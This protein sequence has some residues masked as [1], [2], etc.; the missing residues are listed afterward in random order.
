MA[1][2]LGDRE[3][4]GSVLSSA[5][6]SRGSRPDSEINAMLVEALAIGNELSH[7]GIRAEALWW[8]VPSY[9]SLSDHATARVALA[10][11]TDLAGQLGEP[12][13]LHVAEQYASALALCDG[14]LAAAE[15]A[16]DR[17]HEWSRLLRGRDPSG[18]YGIQ[19][20][21]IRREQ[22]RLAELAPVV[23]LLAGQGSS[24]AWSPAL[25]VLLA[26]L[27][28]ADDA[29]R[30]LERIRADGLGS[31]GRTLWLATLAYVT[32][33]AV[34]VGDEQLAAELYAAFAPH[35][36]HNIQ[37][38][39]LVACLGSADRYLGMLATTLGDWEEADAHFRAARAQND[40]LGARTWL[41]HT[42][43]EHARM[44]LSRRIDD[45]RA[46]A[47]ALLGE[48]VVLAEEHG[49][50]AVAQRASA[51]GAGAA[52]A[53]Q[54]PDG[55]SGREVQILTFVALG[56]SNREVGERLHISEHTVANHV[57]SILRKTGCA[58]RTEATSYAHRHRL[59]TA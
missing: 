5:Y 3:A 23:R 20:F 32:E 24:A 22:G 9:V 16:A 41:A 19:M 26:D 37:I 11:L 6:W 47:A 52:Q 57:R 44:L 4:L 17:S 2:A 38:G 8:L 27:G 56:L 36:G 43:V 50:V 39:H 13:R 10:E 42:L 28:M 33:A 31:V 34:A 35:R 48:A 14:D 12:F 15:A 51:L 49:L 59:V 40:L 7:T 18:V 45:D 55:L 25:A 30:E 54:S 21:G 1:R 53:R 58:N 46:N 29:V